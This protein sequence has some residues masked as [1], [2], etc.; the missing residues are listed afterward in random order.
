MDTQFCPCPF[1]QVTVEVVGGVR[2]GGEYEHLTIGLISLCNRRIFDLYGNQ[3][4]EFREFGI[5]GRGR[6]LLPTGK[7]PQAGLCRAANP[8]AT[9]QHQGAPS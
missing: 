2:K 1:V 3:F 6:L 9:V 7:V 5:T 8:P 4:F